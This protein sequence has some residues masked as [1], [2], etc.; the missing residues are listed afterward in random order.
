[1]FITFPTIKRTT[2]AGFT[3]SSHY[4]YDGMA[5]FGI[6]EFVRCAEER[7]RFDECSSLKMCVSQGTTHSDFIQLH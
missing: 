4:F 3:F 1:M 7:K 5:F 6:A 2:G